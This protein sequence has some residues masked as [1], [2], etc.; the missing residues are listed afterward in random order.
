MTEFSC[1]NECGVN[2][3]DHVVVKIDDVN[4][5]MKYVELH[6]M[7]YKDGFLKIPIHC[8]NLKMNKCIDYENRPLVCR[9]N[10]GKNGTPFDIKECPY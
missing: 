1:N 8:K 6:S 5:D 4:V 7:E 10:G 9:T 2:C 3:C